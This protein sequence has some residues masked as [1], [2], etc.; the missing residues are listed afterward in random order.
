MGLQ[1]YEMGPS[2]RRTIQRSVVV[3]IAAH[4]LIGQPALSVLTR[5]G[6]AEDEFGHVLTLP[7][8]RRRGCQSSVV[9]MLGLGI[10]RGPDFS[11]P[12]PVLPAVSKDYPV[13]ESA[14]VYAEQEC[15]AIILEK[16]EG[17]AKKIDQ[18][19][20]GRGLLTTASHLV[21][22][23]LVVGYLLMPKGNFALDKD[24]LV[25]VK[26]EFVLLVDQEAV[27]G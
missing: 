2:A 3:A 11:Q 6:A 19:L 25:G 7:Q 9:G 15:L 8:P 21:G 13:Q 20:G 18:D 17:L 5:Y 14:P 4:R 27:L 26:S 16:N 24:K 22:E 23:Q 12:R 10:G 1:I